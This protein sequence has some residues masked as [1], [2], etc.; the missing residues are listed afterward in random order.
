MVRETVS[1]VAQATFFDVLFDGIE[2]FFLGDLHLGVGPT[3]DLDDHVEYPIVLVSKEGDIMEGREDGAV[4]LDEDSMVCNREYT[5]VMRLT[6]K[7]LQSDSPNVF[8][9]PT[10]RGVYSDHH[11]SCERRIQIKKKTTNERPS[12]LMKDA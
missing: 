9:A 5:M 10:R 2:R 7:T 4:L 1:D 12:V 6:T 8:G 11:I 3:R